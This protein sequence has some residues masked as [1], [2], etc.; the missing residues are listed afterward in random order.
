MPSVRLSVSP[1]RRAAARF[2]GR[3]HRELL[4]AVSRVRADGVKQTDIARAIGV[5]RS[6]INRQL[7][8]REDISLSRIGE[9][10]HAMGLEPRFELVKPEVKDGQNWRSHVVT[11]NEDTGLVGSE[12]NATSPARDNADR[13]ELVSA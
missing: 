3:V 12:G 9:M 5:H 8:G 11:M 7:H 10:A 1:S 13:S 6:V 2:V 4:G